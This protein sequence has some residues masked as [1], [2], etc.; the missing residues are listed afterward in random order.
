MDPSDEELIR[1]F[2]DLQT[3]EGQSSQ[4]VIIP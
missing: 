1:R 2:A 4:A 3:K